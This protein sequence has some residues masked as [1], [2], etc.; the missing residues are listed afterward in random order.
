MKIKH[1]RK[2]FTSIILSA[3][4]VLGNAAIAAPITSN[5]ASGAPVYTKLATNIQDGTILHCFDW[6]YQQIIDELPNIAAAGFT[7]VQTS[8]AQQ[9]VQ[10]NSIWYYLYQPNGFYISNSGLGSENDLK[11]LCSEADKYGIKVIVDVVANHLAGDHSNIDGSLKDSQYWHNG[12]GSIDY[13]NRYQITHN[14]IGMPDIN[15]EHST[16]QDKVRN[17]IQQLK[18]DGVDGIRW[19]AA[20]HISLPSEG[21]NFWNSVIDRSMFNYGEILD[22][23]VENNQSFANS[24]INEYTSYMSVTDSKYCSTILGEINGGSVSG[25]IGYWTQVAGVSDNKLVYW[26]E[27]HDTYSNNTNEGGWTKYIDQNKIDRAYAIVASRNGAT[28]L[29]FSRPSQTEKTAIMVGQKGST[30]FTSDEVAAVNHFHNACIGEPDYYTVS[31]NVAVTTRKSGAVLVLGSGSNQDVSVPNG[32]SY[33]T[34]GEYIDE[35]SGNKF[36]VTSTTI[37]GRIGSTGIAVIYKTIPVDEPVISADKESQSFT[38]SIT[39][40]F[41]IAN[42]DSYTITVN[43]TVNNSTTQT[44][45][46]DTT[47]VINASNAA[48][49]VSKEYKYTKSSGPVDPTE[50]RTIYLD[51]SSCSWFTNDSAVA[52]IKTNK[53][54][55]YTKMTTT[56]VDGKTVYTTSVPASATSATVVRMLPSGNYYNEKQISLSSSY[57]Y[58]TSDGNWST[59]TPSYHSTGDVKPT[60]SLSVDGGTYNQAVTVTITVKNAKNASYTLD[61]TTKSF[62]DTATVTISKTST[63]TVNAQNGTESAQ[64]SAN[65]T[66]NSSQSDIISVYFTNNNNWGKVYAYT[67]GGSE[68][69]S[70]WPGT[71]MTYV[72]TNQY[73]EKI[74]KINIASD[75]KGLIFS[76]G[77]GTQTVDITSGIVNG[78][79]YYITSTNGKCSVGTYTYG[80]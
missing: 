76:N 6:T 25:A 35:V 62:T 50:K 78:Q 56:T 42:A 21:C 67:W 2:A 47:V 55:S 28:S 10:G 63:L 39:V 38:D 58:Y 30:H 41:N 46:N 3:S 57:N 72:S 43:G 29:Y 15:S 71:E 75:V 34:P 12:G 22:N 40:N 18:N 73:N 36:T 49:S 79:G 17:Y 48:G 66:I 68:N 19:D 65:Y 23:P 14:D 27:S 60:I 69:T 44:F 5:A 59:V 70:S 37:S 11:R 52:A 24:L 51:T 9:A 7:S 26:A 64:K 13:N 61:G 80:N 74:Y 32:G 33:T 8:P 1:L 20:K 54:S 16:V 45:T 4:L 53:D 77:S 31:G